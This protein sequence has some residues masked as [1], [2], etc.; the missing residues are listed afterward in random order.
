[1]PQLQALR[2]L[3]DRPHR[4]QHVATHDL[5]DLLLVVPSVEQFLRD[6]GVGR[7]IVEL[8]GKRIDAVEVATDANV[9]DTSDFDDMLNMVHDVVNRAGA[10]RVLLLPA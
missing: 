2:H 6:Q 10:D 1:M 9:I 7:D 4:P 8:L 3:L 5:V